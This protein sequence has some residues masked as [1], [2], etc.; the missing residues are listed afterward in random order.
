MNKEPESLKN[1]K[2]F[3]KNIQK[4]W[5]DTTEG[6]VEVEKQMIKQNGRKGRMD[7]FIQIEETYVSIAEMKMS[8]WDAMT[9]KNL[10]KNVRRQIRQIW[11]YIDSQLE[12]NRDVTPGIIFSNRPKKNGRLD[13]IE[14]IF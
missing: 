6:E 3:H 1:G 13:L 12:Q 14:Q 2:E 8:D 7:V 4:E 5:L 11:S 10:H 9:I